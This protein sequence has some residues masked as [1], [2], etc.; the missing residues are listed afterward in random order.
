MG[1][2]DVDGGHTTLRSPVIDLTGYEH[3]IFSYWRWYVNAPAG[4]ANPGT[5]WWQVQISDDGG[6]S[7]VFIEETRTQENNWR[8]K[9]F[10]VEDFVEINDQFRIQMIASDSVFVGENLDGG[11]LIEAAVDDIFLWDLPSVGVE[12]QA[13]AGQQWSIFPNPSEGTF[14]L[15]YA[16]EHSANVQV[17]ITNA[18]G[19]VIFREVW[20]QAQGNRTLHL[21]GAATGLYHVRMIRDGVTTVKPL[22]IVA[23]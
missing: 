7:W 5:D 15:N 9:A 6:D 3:P 16:F 21:D 11:S 18:V 19:Q 13:D 20:N 4:G 2:N 22:Q 23:P 12:E 17:E 8:R 10:R 14:T 1:T